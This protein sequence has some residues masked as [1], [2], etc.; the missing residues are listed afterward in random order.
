LE[1]L[2]LTFDIHP[3]PVQ[4]RQTRNHTTKFAFCTIQKAKMLRVCSVWC[5]K[6]HETRQWWANVPSYVVSFDFLTSFT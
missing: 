6:T 5:V 1:A 2:F 3:M 4:L